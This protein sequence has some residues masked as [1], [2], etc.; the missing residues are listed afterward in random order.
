MGLAS[1]SEVF[2]P[3]KSLF[4]SAALTAEKTTTGDVPPLLIEF[5][6]EFLSHLTFPEPHIVEVLYSFVA[7]CTI[8]EADSHRSPQQGTTY[9]PP[10]SYATTE[11]RCH[12]EYIRVVTR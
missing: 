1:G 10:A 12:S 5:L 2:S 9:V 3:F 4:R 8:F 7:I 11:V 6:D